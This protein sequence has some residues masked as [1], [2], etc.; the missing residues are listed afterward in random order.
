MLTGIKTLSVD[1][2]KSSSQINQWLL[3]F[4]SHQQTIAETMLS[5]LWFVRRD[6]YSEWLKRALSEL[7][8]EQ[9]HAV[10]AVRKLEGTNPFFWQ[11]DGAPV[12]RSPQSLGSEDLVYS[13]ISN[14]G[15]VS[16]GALLDHPSLSDIKA[17]RVRSVVLIDDS[18]GSGQR[19]VDFINAMFRNKQ[20][21]SWWSLGWVYIKVI[22][23][24]RTYSSER[25]IVH[26]VRGS[27]HSIRTFPKSTKIDFVSELRYDVTWLESRWGTDFNSIVDLCRSVTAIP[28]LMQEGFGGVMGNLIFYHSVPDNIP[29]MLW[30]DSNGW[31][32]LFPNR[33]LPS[34][35]VSLLEDPSTVPSSPTALG[36]PDK[37]MF[38]L[39]A[40]I[41]SGVRTPFS[42]S[43]R[44]NCDTP[45]A[46]ALIAR[47]QNAGL[48]SSNG[49]LTKAGTDFFYKKSRSSDVAA[50]DYSM[51]IPTSWS[52]D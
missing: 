37:E 33:G 45:F 14:A 22:S 28:S 48:V 42:L 44:M 47:A 9:K 13:V 39:I 38:R 25:Y 10:Y 41:K 4:P 29:G 46:R 49:R 27:N 23:F 5:R 8:P 20:F 18:I 3:Q 16:Q 12:S 34:W 1:A 50:Y 30:S 7:A 31:L 51:Y 40:L 2:I 15:K 17:E 24:A 6:I 26:N 21:M 19:V 35:T 36:G 43:L 32:P 11:D 52:V